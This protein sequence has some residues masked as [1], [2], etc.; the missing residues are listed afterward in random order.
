MP[1]DVLL[2][3][4]VVNSLVTRTA[5]LQGPRAN[6]RHSK[7]PLAAAYYE[8]VKPDALLV[9]RLDHG[10]KTR[11]LSDAWLDDVLG[12]YGFETSD[13]SIIDPGVGHLH[14]S[15]GA[16]EC[17]H[18]CARGPAAARSV[19][20]RMVGGLTRRGRGPRETCPPSMKQSLA[21]HA[22]RHRK[23]WCPL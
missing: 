8:V 12:A 1:N 21:G 6:L 5:T 14:P 18:T 22:R 13:E 11:E 9:W 20:S 23:P 17:G 2:K 7:N 15:P 10:T 4:E 16:L 19:E 3:T